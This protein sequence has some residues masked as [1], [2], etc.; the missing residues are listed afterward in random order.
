MD[1]QGLTAATG[2]E[3]LRP[4][5]SEANVMYGTVPR[6]YLLVVI[7]KRSRSAWLPDAILRAPQGWHITGAR[8][9]VREPPAGR[10]SESG[11]R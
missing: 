4:Y 11:Q 10:T 7:H 3:R 9:G 5:S 2:Q 8:L 1:R 6:R